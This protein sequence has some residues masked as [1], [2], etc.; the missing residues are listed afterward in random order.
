MS[1]SIIGGDFATATAPPDNTSFPSDNFNRITQL[2]ARCS[3]FLWLYVALLYL[4]SFNGQWR[5][6]LDSANY[7]GLA[8]GLATGRGYSFGEWAPRNVYP[9]FP[10][11]LAGLEKLFGSTA[12]A[13]CLAMLGM[14]VLT[15]LITYRLMRLHYPR[16]VAVTVTF[17]LATNSWYLQQTSELMTDV[18]FL[19]GVVAALY[20]WDLLR[21]RQGSR[22]RSIAILLIGLTIAATTRPTS[23]ILVGAWGAA[24]A[25]GILTERGP[26][27][28]FYATALVIMLGVWIAFVALDP[29]SRG[30]HPLSGGGYE[31]EAAEIITAGAPTSRLEQVLYVLNDQLP[32]GFFGEQLSLFSIKAHGRKYSPTSIL[33]SIVLLASVGLLLRRHLAWALLAWLTFIATI[34]Y[35]AE[36]RYY[37]MVMPIL[38]LAWLKL[39]MTIAQRVPQR[40]GE[41][42]LGIGLAIVVGNN[43]SRSINFVKEQR[44][45]PFL[46]HYKS[47]KWLPAYRMAMLIRERLPEG[48]AVL[49]PS[50]SV[51]SYL[52]DHHVYSQREIVPTRGHVLEFPRLLYDKHIA[53]AVFPSSLYKDKEPAIRRLMERGIMRAGRSRV[54]ETNGW[55]LHRLY[56]HVPAGDW[57]KIAKGAGIQYLDRPT[58]R[59]AKRPPRPPP[60]T[61]RAPTTSTRPARPPATRNVRPRPA[62][63][64]TR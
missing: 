50:G 52:S 21:L 22:I 39:L 27:R 25:W 3:K 12:V 31:R 29:R 37:L 8:H 56:V 40:W 38:L 59:P 19:L 34:L 11:L 47:G 45:R 46:E 53:Y 61:R 4:I 51:M 5:I 2:I 6:G 10:L 26:A 23:L 48:A 18:P 44:S 7:R 13:P 30:F 14:S 20:G 49:G 55:R 33:G 1:A 54:A 62:T 63:T 9:G 36:P 58:T 15:L 24:C 41:L 43:F 64:Q 57:T 60:T 42:F 35:A 28:R 32:S 16:W 17:G